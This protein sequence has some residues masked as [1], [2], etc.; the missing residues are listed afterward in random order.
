[1]NVLCC[2]KCF[3]DQ[4]LKLF[5]RKNRINGACGYCGATSNNCIHPKELAKMFKPLLELFTEELCVSEP[6]GSN[7]P[8]VINEIWDIFSDTLTDE[9][10]CSLLSA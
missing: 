4:D 3:V 5:I 8:T 1:M 2:E 7:L 9:A 10:R 6:Q